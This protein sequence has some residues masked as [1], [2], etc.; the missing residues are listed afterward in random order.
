MF[1][2][3]VFG[4][5]A[6]HRAGGIKNET[7]NKDTKDGLHSAFHLSLHVNKNVRPSPRVE[8]MRC[9]PLRMAAL[10]LLSDVSSGTQ[11]RTS[12]ARARRV[13]HSCFNTLRLLHL[14][15]KGQAI[16]SPKHTSFSP[17][18]FLHMYAHTDIYASR[19]R[20]ANARPANRH[21][22]YIKARCTTKM[23]HYWQF[24]GHCTNRFH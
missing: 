7:A 10:E 13:Q 12:T 17:S 9:P 21:F 15:T 19:T 22:S 3:P 18:I 14:G 1:S 6:V 16:P 11:L 8:T 23:R 5:C 20:V 4:A 2:P 24:S